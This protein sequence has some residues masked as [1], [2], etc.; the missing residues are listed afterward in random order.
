MFCHKAEGGLMF[1]HRSIRSIHS[2][3]ADSCS[4]PTPT[5]LLPHHLTSYELGSRSNPHAH[6]QHSLSHLNQAQR[7]DERCGLSQP[8]AL[9]P[10]PRLRLFVDQGIK[11][12]RDGP[13]FS[14]SVRALLLIFLLKRLE[15]Q[16]DTLGRNPV[17]AAARLCV[18]ANDYV[19]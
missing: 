19:C 6:S 12:T 8:A 15:S 14:R 1:D 18:G 2:R 17:A 10:S 13:T 3:Q 4:R 9:G 11:A 5:P 7:T 16:R